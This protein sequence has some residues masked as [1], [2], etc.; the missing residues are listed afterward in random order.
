[1]FHIAQGVGNGKTTEMVE[2]G[3]S[4]AEGGEQLRDRFSVL[5]DR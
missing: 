1:M 4:E 5:K 3:A 2:S